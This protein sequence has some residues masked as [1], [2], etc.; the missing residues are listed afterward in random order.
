VPCLEFKSG[1]CNELL[2]EEYVTTP[3]K[4]NETIIKE[5]AAQINKAF[6]IVDQQLMVL[7]FS[8]LPEC[9]PIQDTCEQYYIDEDDDDHVEV[10]NREAQRQLYY[11]EHFP[12]LKSN[13][14]QRVADKTF[15]KK[16][17]EGNPLGAMR[18]LL[19]GNLHYS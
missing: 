3:R 7:G 18:H 19:P 12:A 14:L 11:C 9:N 15:L 10:D 6:Q 17:Q 2:Q 4:A 13:M 5:L 8:F 1:F 16:V